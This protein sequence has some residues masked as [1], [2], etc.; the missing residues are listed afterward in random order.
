MQELGQHE[1]DIL[2]FIERYSNKFGFSPTFEEIKA[3]TGIRSKDHVSRDL[4][5]LTQRGY[6]RIARRVSRGITLLRTADGYPVSA[7]SYRIP[8][9]GCIS[10]GSPMP[11]PDANTI[12]IDWVQVTRAMIPDS[13]GVFALRVRGNS[14]IDAL[15]NDGDT[16]LMKKQA[17]A[18]N[19]NL[20]AVRLKKDPTNVGTT[21][22]RFY[23]KNGRV[24]LQPENPTLRPREYKPSDVE[25]QGIVLCV[26]RNIPSGRADNTLR[27]S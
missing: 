7:G 21:L 8:I 10:A 16:V 5:W 12:A 9:Y 11:L 2:H 3:H 14:M 4:N 23:R 6:L 13:E 25:V 15:V 17:T 22:K 18:S 19:G 24:L 20:V 27:L 26:I 1:R